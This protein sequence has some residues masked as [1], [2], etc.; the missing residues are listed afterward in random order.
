M[1]TIGQ[2]QTKMGSESDKQ[3]PPSV[4][5]DQGTLASNKKLAALI[6]KVDKS[7]IS[8]IKQAVSKI[9]EIINNPDS[10][11]KELKDVIEKDPPLSARLLKR[12]NSAFYGLRRK[13]HAIQEAIV[14][15]GFNAVK[16]LAMSQKVSEVFQGSSSYEGY[17]RPQLWEHSLAVAL[18]T[19][20]TYAREFRMQGEEIYVAGLLHDLG[21]I[22][23]DQFLHDEFRSALVESS[24]NKEN[25]PQAENNHMHFN[26][27]DVGRM[28]ANNWGFPHELARAIGSHHQPEN[29]VGESKR[30]ILTLYVSDYIVQRNE[31]GYCDAPHNRDEA[32]YYNCLK[33]LGIKRMAMNLI[34]EDVQKEIAD[35]KSSGWM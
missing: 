32:L 33:E 16:E 4:V 19:K 13:V 6:K 10:S 29:A 28:I 9:M 25:L 11:A 34:V 15:I 22:A 30:M 18:C 23:E 12:A 1:E 24:E 2:E 17:S 8:S 31:I 21:I 27:A 26:H 20:L 5:D 35:L 14:C 7:D 3:I